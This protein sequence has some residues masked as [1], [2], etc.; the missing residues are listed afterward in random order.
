MR[1]FADVVVLEELADI[2]ILGIDNPHINFRLEKHGNPLNHLKFV[3]FFHFK[4]FHHIFFKTIAHIH[5]N[6]LFS[7]VNL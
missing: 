7:D 5:G 4:N 1:K 2:I 3:E 6:S